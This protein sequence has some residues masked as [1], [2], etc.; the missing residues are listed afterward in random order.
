[1]F[2]KKFWVDLSSYEDIRNHMAFKIQ[3]GKLSI[4]VT[5]QHILFFFTDDM[6]E[7]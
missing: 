3:I 7:Y 1:M 4:K 2:Q 6:H 5:V